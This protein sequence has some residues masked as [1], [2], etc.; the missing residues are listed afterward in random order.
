MSD[1]GL[2]DLLDVAWQRLG[3]GAADR[4]SD[5]RTPVLATTGLDG[6]PQARVLVLRR[7]DRTAGEVELH[8]DTASP[9][10]AE[11]RA[12]PRA[13]LTV[14]DGKADLQIRL[15]LT[16][17]ILAGDAVADRWQRVPPGSRL[18]YGGPRPGA[19]VTDPIARDLPDPARFAVLLGRIDEIDLLHLGDRHLRALYRR[20]D[21]FTGQW[22]AP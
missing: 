3:R 15:A 7:V 20:A 16:V 12:D 19:P 11:L 14:W 13:A 9:K 1:L 5:A 4:R 8:T 21:G 17:T 22:L 6:R 18:Q 10:V 2:A